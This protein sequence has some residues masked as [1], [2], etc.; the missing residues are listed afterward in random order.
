MVDSRRKLAGVS[1]RVAEARLLAVARCSEQDATILTKLV[2]RAEH[3]D[4][5]APVAEHDEDLL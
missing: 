3:A 1:W 5:L 2:V 4:E